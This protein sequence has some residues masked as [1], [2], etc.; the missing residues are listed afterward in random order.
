MVKQLS[1]GFP[2]L[3]TWQKEGDNFVNGTIL[4]ALAE[5]SSLILIAPVEIPPCVFPLRSKPS[6]H[7]N[8]AR[9]LTVY[10]TSGSMDLYRSLYRG[11]PRHR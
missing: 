2:G 11:G 7:A 4:S 8:S 10:G 3:R 5:C 1:N 6:R 9:G